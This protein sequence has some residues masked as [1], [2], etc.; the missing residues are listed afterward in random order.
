M[1][2]VNKDTP[3]FVHYCIVH[4][5][6]QRS[7]RWPLRILPVRWYDKVYGHDGGAWLSDQLSGDYRILA[8]FGHYA[9]ADRWKK[10]LS[11][12]RFVR[13]EKTSKVT[14]LVA[15]FDRCISLEET[16]NILR[17]LSVSEDPDCLYT[18]QK[19]KESYIQW[20]KRQHP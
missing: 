18:Y 1:I 9:I 4:M 17:A 13:T 12:L 8:A 6:G 14:G 19:D 7:K 10:I 5:I 20:L 15:Q 16:D 3:H 11:Q 2:R